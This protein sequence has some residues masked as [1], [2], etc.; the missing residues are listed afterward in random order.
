MNSPTTR[1][2]TRTGLLLA[3]T[4]VLQGLRLVIPLM[5]Q[6]SMFLIGSLVN[7]CFVIAV[8]AVHWRAGVV[9]AIVTP[10]FAWLEGMLPVPLFMVPVAMGNTVFVVLMYFLGKRTALGYAGVYIAAV[11]KM[12]VLYGA[13]YGLFGLVAFPNAVRQAI[14]FSMSWP[15]LWTGFLGGTL[16]I[17]ISRRLASTSR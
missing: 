16:G 5:P 17:L 13:F 14:L 6:V 11:C 4:L 15:Q 8:F 3:A 12:A 2:L 1:Q 9:V 10:L 7:A